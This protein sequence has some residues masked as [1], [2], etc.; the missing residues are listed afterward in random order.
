MGIGWRNARANEYGT[1]IARPAKWIAPRGRKARCGRI[2]ERIVEILVTVAC[3]F[4][5]DHA[6]ARRVQNRIE[7]VRPPFKREVTMSRGREARTLAM[8]FDQNDVA[9]AQT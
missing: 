5:H 7:V 1:R 8:Q 3:C 2:V 4:D 9:G 6:L